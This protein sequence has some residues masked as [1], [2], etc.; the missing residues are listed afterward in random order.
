M[1]CQW[2]ERI[3]DKR[4]A[5]SPPPN[6]HIPKFTM[7]WLMMFYSTITDSAVVS[8]DLI[9]QL[10]SFSN[11]NT[12]GEAEPLAASSAHLPLLMH[13]W[14]QRKEA[15]KKKEG[16]KQRAIILTRQSP[17]WNRSTIRAEDKGQGDEVPYSKDTRLISSLIKPLQN[18]AI[19]PRLATFY[20]EVSSL[21]FS[22][23]SILCL[24]NSECPLS[25]SIKLRSSVTFYP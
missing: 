9:S 21:P 17:N 15:G 13:N 12:K 18:S 20:T 19:F 3:A 10:I 22:R 25:A 23:V 7:F 16:G 11:V 8:R 24:S 2:R 1:E 4:A 14:L 5:D 6:S